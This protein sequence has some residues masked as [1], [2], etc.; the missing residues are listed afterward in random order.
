MILDRYSDRT[1]E[2]RAG[3]S[4]CALQNMR[5]RGA[6]AR[7]YPE[8]IA[9]LRSVR[10]P[11]DVGTVRRVRALARLGWSCPQIADVAGI[12]ATTIARLRDHDARRWVGRDDLRDG[13]ALAYA[14]LSMKRPPWTRWSS[15]IA[16]HAEREG[17]PPPL[18]WDDDLIDDPAAVASGIGVATR[19][20]ARER[21]YDSAD[22][23]ACARCGVVREVYRGRGDLCQDCRT[24]A[25]R[26]AA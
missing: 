22:H 21:T 6:K 8:T 12:P 9:R 26:E 5:K 11:T 7:A 25:R 1:L 24:V 19:E 10:I 15:R 3:V 13:V 4:I 14:E 20:P 17:W 16:G 2:Q 18:A 23:A